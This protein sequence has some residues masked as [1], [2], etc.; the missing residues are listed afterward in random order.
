MKNIYILVVLI[1]LTGCTYKSYDVYFDEEKNLQSGVIY[2][3]IYVKEI[4]EG[5]ITI[6]LFKPKVSKYK[7]S[8]KRVIYKH[9]K[10][11][12]LS[13]YQSPEKH[14]CS[15]RDIYLHVN[16]TNIYPSKGS[17][18]GGADIVPPVVICDYTFDIHPESIDTFK[19]YFQKGIL[20]ISPIFLYKKNREIVNSVPLS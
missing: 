6:K 4:Q 7:I 12:I 5:N 8:E 1:S 20:N 3:K 10:L 15:K 9:K 16:N 13:S 18:F 2:N 19:L 17:L 14:L 11:V